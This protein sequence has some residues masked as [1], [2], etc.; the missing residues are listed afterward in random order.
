MSV[1]PHLLLFLLVIVVLTTLA[2]G[3]ARAQDLET[4]QWV[5]ELAHYTP[6]DADA[7]NVWIIGATPLHRE[8]EKVDTL[9]HLLEDISHQSNTRIAHVYLGGISNQQ[10]KLQQS[11]MDYVAASREFQKHPPPIGFGRWEYKNSEKMRALVAEG[12]MK[13]PFV[14]EWNALLG[15]YGKSVRSASMEKLFFIKDEGR[16]GWNAAVWLMIDPPEKQPA[17]TPSKK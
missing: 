4:L 16:W 3:A 10:P 7:Y 2:N 15:K 12:V 9:A 13:S 8:N 17:K 1:L 6:A 14:A 5:Y 11:V